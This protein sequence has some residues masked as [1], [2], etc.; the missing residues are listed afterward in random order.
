MKFNYPHKATQKLLDMEPKTYPERSFRR[1][2]GCLRLK[3]NRMFTKQKRMLCYTCFN[4]YEKHRRIKNGY[5]KYLQYHRERKREESKNKPKNSY[6]FPARKVM[7][8]NN[9]STQ[10]EE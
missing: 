4:E 8:K 10:E 7:K 6:R 5:E 3:A 1:C 9:D 2:R